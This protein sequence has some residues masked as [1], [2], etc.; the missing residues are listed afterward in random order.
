MTISNHSNRSDAEPYVLA[1][2]VIAL[3]RND[4]P[5]PE[6]RELCTSELEDFLKD[7]MPREISYTNP[8]SENQ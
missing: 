8:M 2:Y 7:G 6:L 4:K 1:N 5:R 3:L